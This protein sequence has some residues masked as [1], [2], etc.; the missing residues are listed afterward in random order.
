VLHLVVNGSDSERSIEPGEPVRLTLDYQNISTEPVR[1]AHIRVQ[2]ESVVNGRS[3]TGTSL[4]DWAHVDDQTQGASTTK[5]RLQTIV[6]DKTR[7]PALAEVPSQGQGSIEIG[8]RSLAVASGTKDALI[9][10]ST[11]V[12]VSVADEKTPRVLHAP[13]ITLVYRSDADIAVEPRYFTEEGAPIGAGPL[14]PVAGKA[15]TYRIFWSM[16]KTLHDL[17]DAKVVAVLPK[18]VA[19]KGSTQAASGA[20]T[21]DELTRTVSWNIGRVPEGANELEGWFDVAL[22]PQALDVGRF[23]SLL[24]ETSFQF[25]DAHTNESITRTKPS[26]STDLNQDEGAKGKGVVRK[27]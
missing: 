25:Q 22:T 21:Y 17:N 18:I 15:T 19:W 4:L 23:A 7:L 14:P 5:T 24:G 16:H 6:Y 13:P 10:L 8:W 27:E 11:D 12:Q 1:D 26:L 2:A 20:I 9:R 3:A